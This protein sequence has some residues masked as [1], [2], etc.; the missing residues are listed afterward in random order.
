[1]C[2]SKPYIYLEI[3]AHH[4]YAASYV[5]ILVVNATFFLYILAWLFLFLSF[6]GIT[7]FKNATFNYK[8]VQVYFM[9]FEMFDLFIKKKMS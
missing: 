9:I 6:Q 7:E 4:S 5:G 2:M 3:M 1:M 8:S